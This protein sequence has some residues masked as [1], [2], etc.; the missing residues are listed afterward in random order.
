MKN[1]C[2]IRF[3]SIYA[4]IQSLYS[5]SGDILAFIVSKKI[6]LRSSINELVSDT[7]SGYPFQR[8]NNNTI[9]KI[10]DNAFILL[11]WKSVEYLLTHMPDTWHRFNEEK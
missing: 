4:L 5:N 6:L 1:N 2:C 8:T 9:Q 7:T 11:Q 10:I 3:S